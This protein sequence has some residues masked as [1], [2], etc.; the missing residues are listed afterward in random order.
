M[1]KIFSILTLAILVTA[2]PTSAQ[3]GE[4]FFNL[5]VK[6]GLNFTNRSLPEVAFTS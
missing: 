5:G 1:T 6:S 2:V 4:V 3:T